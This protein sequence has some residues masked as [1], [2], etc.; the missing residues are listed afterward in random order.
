MGVFG[1]FR[2]DG[3]GAAGDDRNRVLDVADGRNGPRRRGGF[4]ECS[5]ARFCGRRWSGEGT[6]SE[7]R[8][9]RQDLTH[10]GSGAR[11]GCEPLQYQTTKDVGA[12]T[13]WVPAWT[14]TSMRTFWPER[15]E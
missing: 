2:L 8:Y 10:V 5:P 13:I 14:T 12:I 15:S 11:E 3:E 6:G 7:V 1:L 9:Y 4:S